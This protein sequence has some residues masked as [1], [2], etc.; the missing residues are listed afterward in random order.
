MRSSGSRWWI[1]GALIILALGGTACGGGGDGPCAGVDC[2][3]H[4]ACR[5]EAGQPR[6]DCDP[7]FVADGLVCHPDWCRD[8]VCAHG[9]CVQDAE[10]GACDCQA[11]W[12]GPSCDGCAAGYHLDNGACLPDEPC[13]ADPCIHGIC[14]V[15]AGEQVCDCDTGYAGERCDRCAAGY[16]AE[17]LD[18]VPDEDNPCAPNPCDEPHRSQCTPEGQGGYVCG[19]DAGYH[20]EG[21]QCVPDDDNPCQPNPCD[22]PNRTQCTPDGAGGYACGCDPGYHDQ[23]G[24]CVPDG[25]DPCDPNPCD[26][27]H[28]TQCTP[29][30]AGGYACD[31]DPGYHD[32][33]GQC[34]PDGGDPCDPNPCDAPHR[35]VCTPDGAGGYACGCDPG[36][37]E[38]AGACLPD[39]DAAADLCAAAQPSFGTLVSSNGHCAVGYDLAGRRADSFLEHLYRNWDEGVWTRDL[40][41]DTYLGLRGGGQQLWLNTAA[42]LRVEYQ[43][44]SHVIHTV[45]QLGVFQLDTW[46]YA[47]FEL[48]RPALVIIGRV[49]NTGDRTESASLFSLHNYHLGNT[50]VEQ[51][52]EPDAADER[53]V[54][55]P[56][57]GAYLETGPGGALLHRPLDATSHH[58]CS[59]DN[60][61]LALTAGQ[62]LADTADSG[63][64]N[65]R[66][67]GFQRDFE[68]APGASGW[69]GVVSGFDRFGDGDS[70]AAELEAVYGGLDGRGALQAALD[71][72]EAWRNP[73]PAGLSPAERWVWRQSEAVLRQGQVRETSDL[74]YGQIVA[75]LPPGNWN[76]CWMRDMAYAIVALARTGHLAEARAALEFVLLA[77]SG[78]YQQDYVGVPYQVTITRYFGRGK[79]ETDFNA[80]GPNIEF[81]GFGLFL[82]SLGAYLDAGGDS[83][84]VDAHW[85]TIRDRIA[86]ALVALIDPQTGLIAAD[87]SI[88][89]VHWNGNQKRY[90]YTSL[91][92]ARGLC[93]AAELAAAR[94]ED[95]L[96][97]DWRAAAIGIR[98]ALAGQVVDADQVLASS[99]EE[100]QAGAGYHDVA[101]V[102]AFDWRL[103]DPQGAIA[104]ATLDSFDA[105]LRVA[106]GRGYFRNDDGGW[107]DSQEWV[108]A[109]LRVAVA[110]RRAGRTETADRLLGWI[111]AQALANHG[112]IAELHHPLDSSYEG[113]IPMV[114][115][116]G[117]AYILALLE[118]EQPASPEPACGSWEAR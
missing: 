84:L 34:V 26:A 58:G 48:E 110:A 61:W 36:Y 63:V 111:S 4:G 91:A 9:V 53:I 57:S 113:E 32:Q 7:G 82:W 59:P 8:I 24:Q 47:P 11:G 100:L 64:G 22:Q 46:I 94:G 62:D 52:V 85:E 2:S 104:A 45:H 90:S 99:Y 33:G 1:L 18:C 73:P 78:H 39:C 16:H 23:G 71:A 67:A 6:C 50:T 21:G 28:R 77:D 44:Q 56:A 116:G 118:R 55:Q 87:S 115:Y 80:D 95:A 27:P 43:A 5:V 15:V 49:T 88:W 81:D 114:G 107:Y 86:G 92:A 66:V 35:T 75:S 10:R 12:A 74:S 17:G 79:E 41:Y 14:R 117:G 30:G 20:D 105:L 25:G 37:H 13:D 68:L 19:C 108:Y 31:C 70:L 102:E 103:F 54:Y 101:S 40:L 96:A 89:E 98:D 112:M 51:P 29:D 42:P 72:F 3:L 93:A 60:P 109:D 76:I 97:A 69:L 65:D 38:V 106:S 83:G